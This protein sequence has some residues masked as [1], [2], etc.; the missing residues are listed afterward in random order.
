MLESAARVHTRLGLDAAAKD[1]E[2][3]Q[4]IQTTQ[5]E[6]LADELKRTREQAN[7]PPEPGS[8]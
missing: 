7:T 2:L 3:R 5:V 6:V 1:P 8:V 4:M